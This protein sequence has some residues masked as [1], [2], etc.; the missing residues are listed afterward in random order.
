MLYERN[1]GI[2]F[3]QASTFYLCV[4]DKLQSLSEKFS[5]L[6]IHTHTNNN[7]ILKWSNKN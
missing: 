1:N 4:C 5:T 6:L 2:G 7:M 3:L